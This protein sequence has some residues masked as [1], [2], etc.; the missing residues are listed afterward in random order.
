MKIRGI[1]KAI[2]PNSIIDY[3]RQRIADRIRSRHINTVSISQIGQDYWVYGECFNEATGFFLDIGAHD[4]VFFSNSFILEERYQWKGI[5]M[6]A[7]PAT[8]AKLKKNRQ[9]R[10]IDVCVDEKEGQVSFA[11]KG[12]W[13]GIVAEDCD[14]PDNEDGA[15]MVTVRAVRL[16]ELLEEEKAPAIIDYLSIDIEGVYRWCN[17]RI[18]VFITLFI[19]TYSP[20]YSR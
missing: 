20:V 13:G 19:T 1:L 12:M 7:N 11:S 4:G 6:E 2:L 10:C 14:N 9:C 16:D 5:C 3:R 15:D 17:K 18:G 8:F